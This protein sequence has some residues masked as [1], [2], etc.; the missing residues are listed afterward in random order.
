[1]LKIGGVPG[2]EICALD[3]HS[4]SMSE[5]LRLCVSFSVLFLLTV[6]TKRSHPFRR[7][8]TALSNSA[9]SPPKRG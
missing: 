3:S 7:S 5:P 8:L 2:N 1:M 6:Q 9:H 4:T